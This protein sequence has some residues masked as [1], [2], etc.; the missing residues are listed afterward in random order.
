M[1]LRL[2]LIGSI[3]VGLWALA[4]AVFGVSAARADQW[5]AAVQGGQTFNFD[6]N[7]RL[8][9]SSPE[10]VFGSATSL[11]GSI[12]RL[13]PPSTSRL[14]GDVNIRRYFGASGL[15]GEDFG[16]GL[17]STFR[18]PRTDY[19]LGA[20]IRRASTLITEQSDTG[21]FQRI[22]N[23]I[24]LAAQSSWQYRLS[25]LE[26]VGLSG[27][28]AFNTY[29]SSQFAEQLNTSAGASWQRQLTINDTISVS[30][31]VAFLNANGRQNTT[32]HSYALLFG[33]SRAI[34]ER[35]SLNASAGPRLA[36]TRVSGLGN[37]ADNE[38]TIGADASLALTWRVT[39]RTSLSVVASQSLEP[40]STGEVQERQ[41]IALIAEHR[42]SERMRAS[43]AVSLQHNGSALGA[44][45]VNQD[46]RLYFATSANVAYQITQTLVASGQYTFR[47]QSFAGDNATA[48]SHGFALVLTYS[49][50]PWSFHPFAE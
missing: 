33:W 16:I 8:S 14:A 42:I 37:T 34:G 6:S 2:D 31:R 9:P 48:F 46:R 49:P 36:F 24:A 40:A 17:D 12:E 20:S 47:L 7:I 43:F 41:R 13:A 29:D 10:S 38:V 26:T 45:Q 19:R 4:T 18:T 39:E 22:A 5:K 27:A 3:A 44:S 28:V 21:Q 30:A 23:Q 1:A 25:P 11:A 32:T 15:D 35:I 50:R